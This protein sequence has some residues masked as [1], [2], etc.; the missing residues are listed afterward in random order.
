[1]FIP[2]PGSEFLYPGPQVKGQ[3]DSGS[4]IRIKKIKVFLAL[5]DFS[6]LSENDM[7]C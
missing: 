2:Y 4:R 7:E 3:E 6:K 5:K 1:M